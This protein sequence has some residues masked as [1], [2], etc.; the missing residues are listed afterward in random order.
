MG[1]QKPTGTQDLLP[2]VVERWQFIEE[3]AR[4]LCR[5]FNYREIRT[6][7]FE[8]TSLFE[9]GV[10]ETT[11]IV[12]KEMYTFLDK[13]ERSMTL[14]PEGTAG[15]VRS[16]VENKLYGE[17]DVSKL[18]YIG[19]MF[20]YERPQAGR[21]RQ[22]HQF[23]IEAIGAI[24]PAID[25]EVISLGYEL[26]KELGLHGVTVEVNSVGNP[27]SRADY[28]EKLLAF[29]TP[30]KDS[31]CKD[32][33]SRMER[34]PM[35]VLDC[36]V[37]QDKFTGAPSIL[38]SLD[39][40][41]LTHFEQVKSYLT[42]MNVD[43]TINHRLVRGLDYYTLTAF[44]Y[45]A[46][47]IGAIDTVGGGGRYNKLVAE[48]G[49]PDQP[50]VGL[51]IGLER[52]HLIL[53]NQ[54][55]EVQGYR[56]LDVYLVG[57]GEAADKEITK[58]LFKLRK[59]GISAERDYLGR[60]MKAQLKSADRMQARYTAILGDDELARGEIAVKLMETGEQRTVKLEDLA[61]ELK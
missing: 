31:L 56:P 32:C 53:E 44:E 21:Q 19:P 4:D 30:M 26:C 40:E 22:F 55:I 50:G 54:N 49:G 37:D 45:K 48:V 10:G 43:Y 14:R 18:Y 2:G 46:Q 1:F 28:R 42:D 60:K 9:R 47:G 41:S 5:R 24:D 25:A 57:L 7:I 15:V 11:D 61:A 20:R 58:Q 39:E 59:A 51:A 38:D 52:I 36:K 27:Q 6:P 17:P 16:Y 8:Q 23:G 13:G 3:K 35:R 12:E 33:Q 34:N 29:L